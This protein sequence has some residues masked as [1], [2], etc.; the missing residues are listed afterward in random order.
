MYPGRWDVGPDQIAADFVVVNHPMDRLADVS[1]SCP[2]GTSRN[3]SSQWTETDVLKK[4]ES[5][6]RFEQPPQR[7]ENRVDCFGRKIVERQSGDDQIIVVLACELFDGQVEDGCPISGGDE[8]R[9]VL[10]AVVEPGHELIVQFD[11]IELVAGPHALDNP[12]RDCAGAWADFEDFSVGHVIVGRSVVRNTAALAYK[13]S[14][15]P[16]Q[17]ATAGKDGTGRMK[18]STEFA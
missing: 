16:A 17:G 12:G 1:K 2:F 18:I 10:Q 14:K 4:R 7:G 11:Q 15:S 6:T 13:T 8:C 9:I 5:P 3:D